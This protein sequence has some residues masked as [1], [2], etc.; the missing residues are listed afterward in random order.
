MLFVS[1][2]WSLCYEEQFYVVTGVL[3]MTGRMHFA[4]PLSAM[5][6]LWNLYFLTT[7]HGWFVDY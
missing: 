7:C 2:F 6:L 5:S 1:V 3:A 4:L